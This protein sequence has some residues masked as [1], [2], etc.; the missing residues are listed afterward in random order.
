MSRRVALPLL[1]LLLGAPLALATRAT[2]ACNPNTTCSGNGTCNLD[3]SCACFT[4]FAGASCNQCAPN[5]YNYPTCTF[6]QAAVTCNGNGTCGPSGSCTCNAGFTGPSCSLCA[7]NYYN[8]PT[9][10]FCLA[11]TTC[12]GNGVCNASG[13]CNCN[14]GITGA[15]CN[16]CAPNYYNYPTCTFCL[17]ATTC[18]GNGVCNA[19]GGCNCNAG[20]SGTNCQFGVTT[21]T[22]STSTS[23][24]TSTTVP[25]PTC[26]P[27]PLP[28]CG[29][30]APGASS[31]LLKD[32][33]D[34]TKDVLTW[35]WIKGSA[36]DVSAF[37]D[38]VNG[39]T[40]PHLCVY[41]ASG[42][43]QPLMDTDV[44]PGGTCA[45]VPCWKQTGTTGFAYKNKAGST[46]GITV[47]T[48]KVGV[49]GKAKVQMNGK[50]V[51]L[52]MPTL[53]L[54]LPVTVQ[55]VIQNG[56]SVQCWQTVYGTATANDTAKFSAKGP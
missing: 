41:D 54:T 53:G 2:A 39:T 36:T 42:N 19:S 6:C 47:V 27:I 43:A 21:T 5:Y 17:A 24:S 49:A 46:E 9:C 38:P 20:F 44:P 55:L 26:G 23:T 22:T 18:N 16:Q 10:T 35:K 40:T 15:S 3:D 29:V 25:P 52:E 48:L 31:I 11:A 7:P 14:T 34:D 33:T 50:G 8:Y 56:M 45:S 12:S 1:V 37:G 30:A 28:G 51:N 32:N 13:G 4:G